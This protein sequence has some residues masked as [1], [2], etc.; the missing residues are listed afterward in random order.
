LKSGTEPQ[1]PLRPLSRLGIVSSQT[2]EVR[3]PVVALETRQ[4]TTPA[5]S[6][7]GGCADDPDAP[8]DTMTFAQA[9]SRQTSTVAGAVA[10]SPIQVKT[11]RVDIEIAVDSG[12]ISR[13]APCG[14]CGVGLDPEV[15]V[16][17]GVAGG[18]DDDAVGLGAD[19]GGGL[20][21]DANLSGVA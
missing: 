2:A 10:L 12:A 7:C 6:G 4:N 20:G 17:G 11:G 13:G 14:L 19:V 1:L 18:D 15:R 16:A 3:P 9:R 21:S 5:G 8:N